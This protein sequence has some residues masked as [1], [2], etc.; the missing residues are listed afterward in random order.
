MN[1]EYIWYEKKE[2]PED[3]TLHIGKSSDGMQSGDQDSSS[4]RIDALCGLV[5]LL[6][7]QRPHQHTDSD[8]LR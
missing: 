7:Q 6:V 3:W 4:Q 1:T 2:T 5:V 8:E